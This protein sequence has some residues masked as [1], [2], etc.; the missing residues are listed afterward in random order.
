MHWLWCMCVSVCVPVCTQICF[1]LIRMGLLASFLNSSSS[2]CACVGGFAFSSK[3]PLY[4]PRI[5]HFFAEYMYKRDRLKKNN[6]CVVFGKVEKSHLK[7]PLILYFKPEFCPHSSLVSTPA[8]VLHLLASMLGE[9]RP[10]KIVAGGE[11]D[12]DKEEG[13]VF[14]VRKIGCC[15]I[16]DVCLF[17]CVYPRLC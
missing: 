2:S 14:G 17:L 10:L 1:I 7:S 13:A 11:L 15:F 5:Y 4:W 3:Q 6:N 16:N 8:C 9:R 12:G